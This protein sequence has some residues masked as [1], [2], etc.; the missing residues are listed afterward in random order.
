MPAAEL[1]ATISISLK[2]VTLLLGQTLLTIVTYCCAIL[3]KFGIP[4]ST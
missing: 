4:L 2:A 1:C 3:F